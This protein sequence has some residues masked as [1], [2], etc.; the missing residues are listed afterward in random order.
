MVNNCEGCLEKQ[1]Q[2]DQLL[3]ENHRLK[4]KLRYQERK[5]QEGVFGAS[6]PSSKVPFKTNASEEK[7]NHKGGALPGHK[8]H[9]RKAHSKDTAEKVIPVD[10]GKICPDCGGSLKLKRIKDRTVIESE[11][12]KPKK[13]LYHLW[14]K[15]TKP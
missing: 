10:V 4:A 15:M 7:K 8:G 5:E 11:P 1:R 9:G 13:I 3:E 2:I 14:T 12:V 6:T